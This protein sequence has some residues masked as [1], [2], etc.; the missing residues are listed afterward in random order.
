V[1]KKEGR[2]KPEVQV[3]WLLISM[4]LATFEKTEMKKIEETE[5]LL[6]NNVMSNLSKIGDESTAI[7]YQSQFMIYF[8]N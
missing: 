3:K 7:L 4:I 5:D 1:S 8:I 2:E 6:E